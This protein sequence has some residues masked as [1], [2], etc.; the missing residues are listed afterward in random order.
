MRVD[1]VE[2][3]NVGVAIDELVGLTVVGEGGGGGAVV[4][5]TVVVAALELELDAISG[6]V[7]KSQASTEQQPLKP[8]AEQTYQLVPD[9]QALDSLSLRYILIIVGDQLHVWVKLSK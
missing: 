8:L 4:K 1:E 3:N 2:D 9:G 7:D 5:V 6:H